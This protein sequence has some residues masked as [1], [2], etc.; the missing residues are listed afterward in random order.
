MRTQ[1]RLLNLLLK[2]KK[3]ESFVLLYHSEWS[4][5]SSRIERLAEKWAQEEGDERLYVVSS[6]ELPHAFAAFGISTAPSIVEV[7]PGKVTVH[8][9]FPKVYDYF[10][11]PKTKK[12]E[13]RS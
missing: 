11:I 4:P 3:T 13:S 2:N 7:K 1:E 9:E 6:W 5:D 10:T 12:A 8:V